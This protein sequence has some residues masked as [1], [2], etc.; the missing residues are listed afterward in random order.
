MRFDKFTLKVQE[1][2]QE[3]QGLASQYGHQA[4]D[5]EHLLV[6]FL[7][8]PEGILPDILKKLGADPGRIEREI[9]KVLE[10]LP[11]I[12]G[13]SGG[14][15]YISPRLNRVLDASLSEAARLTDEY[16]S[17]EHILVAMA[18]EKEGPLA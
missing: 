8:H 16:V 2:L 18:D 17:A 14:Q 9:S 3:A 11:K 6:S 5:S 10:K 12:E 15:T 13:T 4:I 7:K 1:A